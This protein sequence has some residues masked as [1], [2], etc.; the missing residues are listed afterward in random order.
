MSEVDEYYEISEEGKIQKEIQLPSEKEHIQKKKSK[1]IKKRLKVFKYPIII[2][3]IILI[4]LFYNP[5]LEVF[6]NFLAKNPTMYSYYLYIEGQISNLTLTGLFFFSILSSLFFLILPSEATFLYYIEV[7]NHFFLSIILFS[8]LGN[9][10]G[11][12]FNYLFGRILGEKL[13]IK[14]F[15][16]KDFFKYKNIIDKYGGYMLFFGNIF[17]GPIEF[18][19][20]F[21]GGFKFSYKRYIYLTLMGRIIKYIILTFAF[22]FFWN[23][24]TFYYNSIITALSI[25]VFW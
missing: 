16:E 5:I 1:R 14:L 23:E 17:P 18:I 24:I 9:F 4:Y 15:N 20:V 8:I 25:L 3:S 19:A 6:F 12:T 11:M 2:I 13:L 21:Y 10:V 7:T 22:F